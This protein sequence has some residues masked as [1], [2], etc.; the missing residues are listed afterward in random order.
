MQNAMWLGFFAAVLL[1][2]IHRPK[3]GAM[4]LLIATMLC[5]FG[6][7][8]RGGGTTL[9]RVELVLTPLILGMQLLGIPSSGRSFRLAP[10][11][12]LL[13]LWILWLG[14]ASVLGTREINFIGAFGYA[15]FVGVVA[16]FA[17]IDWTD[18]DIERLQF[19]CVF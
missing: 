10:A 1:I 7:F 2:Y 4:A 18:E 5:P 17:N 15:R 3:W 9:L 13:G 16:L 14:I 19:L 11:T 6:D 8:S 12:V